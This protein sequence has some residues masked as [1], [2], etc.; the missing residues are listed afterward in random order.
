MQ[1]RVWALVEWLHPVEVARTRRLSHFPPRK[2]K[3][4]RCRSPCHPRAGVS[5]SVYGVGEI[6]NSTDVNELVK[7]LAAL[8]LPRPLSNGRKTIFVRKL[9]GGAPDY[10]WGNILQ[11]SPSSAARNMRDLLLTLVELPDFQL[12]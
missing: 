3:G 7:N 10:E 6:P 11:D 5:W 1:R 4:P 8:M 9:V 12:C 2:D